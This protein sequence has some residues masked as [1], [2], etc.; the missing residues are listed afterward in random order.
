[1]T[2]LEN[3]TPFQYYPW[4][5]WLRALCAISVM[6]YHDGLLTWPHAGG[7]AVQVFFALSGWL[8]G[9]ILLKTSKDDLTRFYFNRAVRI[10]IP[11]YI[12]VGLLL[13]LSA[14]REPITAK[15]LEIVVYKLLFV[16]NLFGTQQLAEFMHLMPQSGTLNHVWSVNAEEQFYLAAPFLLVL[17]AN[18]MGRHVILWGALAFSAWF[19]DVYSAI[20]LGVLAAVVH[21]RYGSVHLKPIGRA[22]LLVTLMVSGFAMLAT[23]RYAEA[24]P[25][26]AIAIVLLLAVPGPQHRL[27]EVV[28]GMSYPLYLNHW[29][30][31]FALNFLLPTM[32][33]TVL[34]WTLAAALNLAIAIA[35]YFWIEKP[36]LARRRIWFTTGRGRIVTFSAYAMIIVGIVFGFCMTHY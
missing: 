36:L 33:D 10:W 31:I 25:F 32:E 13:L 1:M 15:W 20:V 35:L 12:A 2:H 5:D 29:I 34:R 24:A 21:H 14:L 16:Y 27:G 30:G 23:S 22:L 18:R 4:F 6:L 11:Y 26:A 9:G 8:I 28:G 7:F 3:K 19:L 17:M